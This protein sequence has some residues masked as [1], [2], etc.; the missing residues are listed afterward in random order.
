MKSEDKDDGDSYRICRLG[1]WGR[2]L[3]QDFIILSFFSLPLLSVAL[4]QNEMYG[5]VH[6]LR[7]PTYY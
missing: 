2:G 4:L 7:I 3:D 6:I 1:C 5:G